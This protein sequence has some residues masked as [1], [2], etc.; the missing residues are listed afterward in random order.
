[1]SSKLGE[2]L[3]TRHT[4]RWHPVTSP[5]RCRLPPPE[6]LRHPAG[7][8]TG[9]RCCAPSLSEA[10]DP[11]AASKAVPAASSQS[12]ESMAKEKPAAASTSLLS[13]LSLFCDGAARNLH[14]PGRRPR[15]GRRL[16]CSK[17]P[18]PAVCTL[19]AFLPRPLSEQISRAASCVGL[20]LPMA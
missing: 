9:S 12:A 15:G 18:W 6:G 11:T 7:R 5:L 8:S 14:L 20:A 19:L 1:M 17:S 13:L 2:N 16:R 4:N 3:E 10:L